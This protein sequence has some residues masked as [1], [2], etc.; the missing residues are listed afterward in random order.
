MLWLSRG[1]VWSFFF[2][3]SG[4]C[5][6]AGCFLN[7][8][9]LAE[10]TGAGTIAPPVIPAGTFS[11]TDFGAVP[12]GKTLDTDAFNQAISACVKAGGGSVVVPP[13]TYLLAPFQLASHV[14]LVLEKGA[15]L[16]ATGKFTDSG[17][18][19]PLPSTQLELDLLRPV[20]IPLISGKNLTDV[21]IRGEG[22]I[23]GAGAAWWARS[24]KAERTT[25]QP[26]IPR[27]YMIVLDNCQRV[28]ISGVTL[29]NSPK[30]HLVPR[31]CQDV[32]IENVTVATSPDAPNTDGIDPGNCR[33]LIIRGCHISTGDDNIA[34][35]AGH[36]AP[37]EDVTVEDC[38]FGRGH[39]LSIG[40]ETDAGVRNI[41]ARRCSFNGTTTGIRI[42]SDRTRGGLI[43][44]IT[45]QDMTMNNVGAAISINL[46]YMNKAGEKQAQA[47]TVAATTPAV[48]DILISNVTATA[49][50][51][52]DLIGLPESPLSGITL[53]HVHI[54]AATPLKTQDAGDVVKND[55]VVSTPAG[56]ETSAP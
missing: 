14:A 28:L 47:K 38:V 55:F 54:V 49:R 51:A 34:F 19:D 5:L 13:G 25:H 4:F 46:Y 50:D 56:S 29:T 39:G 6:V 2:A 37:T 33:N 40:S 12:D 11:V 30:F 7:G 24:E 32:L 44:N 36:G 41:L 18:P 9:A 22:T 17:L 10:A 45:Y 27:P 15:T 20:L 3:S 26:S 42:K 43:Q 16:Q 23:D 48:R 52:G 21:A 8:S 31:T 1:S 53:E 35:K